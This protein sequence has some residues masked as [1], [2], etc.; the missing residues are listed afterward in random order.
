MTDKSKKKKNPKI[1][2]AI[3]ILKFILTVDDK[4]II[5]SSIE[6]VID[7]LEDVN[8]SASKNQ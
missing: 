6:G 8:N 1:T 3:E 5:L 4:E 2:Q 7:M